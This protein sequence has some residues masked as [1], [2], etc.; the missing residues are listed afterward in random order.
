MPRDIVRGLKQRR[1]TVDFVRVQDV[2][3]QS[4]DDADILEWAVREGR[5]LVTRDR[6]T[7]TKY[8][9]ERI[10]DGLP[11]LGVFVIPEHMTVGQAVLELELIALASSIEEW[12]DRVIFLP[13]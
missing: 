3:L 9:I 1:P 6:N 11:M 10:A 7:M 13:L 4:C 2:G 12:R 5:L 8:A